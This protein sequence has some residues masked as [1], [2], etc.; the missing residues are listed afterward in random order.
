MLYLV[1]C[2]IQYVIGIL[3]GVL[4]SRHVILPRIV[5]DFLV[6]YSPKSAFKLSLVEVYVLSTLQ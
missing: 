3:A 4:K 5:V 2:I 1:L 6:S